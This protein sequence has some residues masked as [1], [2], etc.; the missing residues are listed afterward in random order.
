MDMDR[1]DTSKE[2][3]YIVR[4]LINIRFVGE[5]RIYISNYLF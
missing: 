1:D 5:K 2:V 3:E 4:K